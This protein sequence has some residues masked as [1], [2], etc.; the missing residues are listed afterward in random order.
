MSGSPLTRRAAVAAGAL[1]AAA[2]ATAASKSRPKPEALVRALL[3][4]IG[5]DFVDG[6]PRLIMQFSAEIFYLPTEFRTTKSGTVVIPARVVEVRKSSAPLLA[7][8][9]AELLRIDNGIVVEPRRMQ[10]VIL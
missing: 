8:F 7:E 3:N 2:P 5:G 1:A 4:Q 9:L 10:V 6:E